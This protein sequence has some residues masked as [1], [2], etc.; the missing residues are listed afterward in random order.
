ME[1]FSLTFLPLNSVLSC[2][3][4]WDSAYGFE[5]CCGSCWLNV[6]VSVCGCVT[7][8]KKRNKQRECD[9]G[10]EKRIVVLSE[11]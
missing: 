9:L 4:Q 8:R 1:V 5:S 3:E 11:V 6:C 7:E 2:Y 10:V